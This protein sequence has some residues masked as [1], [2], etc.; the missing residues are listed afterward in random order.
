MLA[1]EV[2][3]VYALG[4]GRHVVALYDIAGNEVEFEV[5]SETLYGLFKA[6]EDAVASW[7]EGEL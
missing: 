7:H 2:R 4:G 6:A 5:D 3:T 1:P